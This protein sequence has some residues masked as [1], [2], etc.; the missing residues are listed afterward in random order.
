MRSL[1][2]NKE[3]EDLGLNFKKGIEPFMNSNS[4]GNSSNIRTSL[5]HSS[6]TYNSSQ[7]TNNT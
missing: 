6:N 4:R 2:E 5:S 7:N 1:G 3:I